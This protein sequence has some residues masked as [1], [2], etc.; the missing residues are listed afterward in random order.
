MSHVM[1]KLLRTRSDWAVEPQKMAR[2]LT[3]RIKEVEGLYNVCS[4]NKGTDQLRGFRK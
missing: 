3:F 4:K 1:R 2:G